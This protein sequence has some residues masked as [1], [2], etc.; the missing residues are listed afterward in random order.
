MTQSVRSYIVT[1]GGGGIGG[2]TVL[3]LLRTGAN[4]LAIDNSSKPMNAI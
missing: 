1:G 3:R 2:A 4:V